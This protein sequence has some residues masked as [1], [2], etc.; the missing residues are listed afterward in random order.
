MTKSPD[1]TPELQIQINRA[2][3]IQALRENGHRQCVCW[4]EL[5]KA[6]AVHIA[7]ELAGFTDNDHGNVYTW[8]GTQR[9]A[10]DLRPLGAR[11]WR[12]NDAGWTFGQIADAAE[13]GRYW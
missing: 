3:W 2:K 1:V 9:L 4:G 6:C 10:E 8:L 5:E 13:Q 12:D 11:I 7:S